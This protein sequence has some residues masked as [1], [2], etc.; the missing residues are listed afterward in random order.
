MD[1]QRASLLVSYCVR[2]LG[3]GQLLCHGSVFVAEGDEVDSGGPV[4]DV[5]ERLSFC[6]RGSEH[7]LSVGV[8]DG[9][10]AVGVGHGAGDGGACRVEPDFHA[11][12]VGQVAD[13]GFGVGSGRCGLGDVVGDG[14][15]VEDDAGFSGVLSAELAAALPGESEVGAAGHFNE[16]EDDLVVAGAEP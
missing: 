10:V 1:S 9:D 4:G 16:V 5:D 13:A 2:S 11:V 14:L 7:D 3:H 12:A 15:G 8:G 6:G